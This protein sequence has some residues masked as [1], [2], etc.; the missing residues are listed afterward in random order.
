MLGK[1]VY[2]IE[3]SNGSNMDISIPSLQHGVYKIVVNDRIAI[4]IRKMVVQ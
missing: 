2:R 3:K 4:A 1:V